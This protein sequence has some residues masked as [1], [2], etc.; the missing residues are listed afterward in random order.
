MGWSLQKL[1]KCLTAVLY[2]P[3][4]NMI[5]Y[6]NYNW[7]IKIKFFLRLVYNRAL[8]REPPQR[9]LPSRVALGSPTLPWHRHV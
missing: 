1:Y 3:E 8:K 4:I 5:L 7:K 6:L 9:P 2:P